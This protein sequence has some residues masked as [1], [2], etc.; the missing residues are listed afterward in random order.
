MINAV[1]LDLYETLVTQ[2]GTAVPRAGALG[3]SLGLDATAY[4]REWKR[5][6]PLVLRGA[7]TFQDALVEAATR[8]QVALPIERAQQASSDRARANAEV[9]QK[10]DSGLVELTRD[11]QSRGVRLAMVSN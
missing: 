11:L 7:L 4:R 3:E 2:T 6:R 10:I 8:L 1:V 9:F 5:L